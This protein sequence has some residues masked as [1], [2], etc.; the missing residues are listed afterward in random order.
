MESE[1]MARVVQM[2]MD[3][4]ETKTLKFGII[5]GRCNQI[6]VMNATDLPLT[7]GKNINWRKYI[8]M[9]ARREFHGTLVF[10]IVDGEV[11]GYAYSRTYSGDNLRSML[12]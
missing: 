10:D 6:V 12:G 2:H 5:G 1:K 11:A 7:C 3:S 4:G 8:D 9:V